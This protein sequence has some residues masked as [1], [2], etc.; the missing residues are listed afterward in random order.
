MWYP[1]QYSKKQLI[2]TN[3]DCYN[4]ANSPGVKD[5]SRH[6]SDKDML[7]PVVHPDVELFLVLLL[8]GS[9]VLRHW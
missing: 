5:S 4:Y 8:P 2:D 9:V 7:M 6:G 3:L 1:V